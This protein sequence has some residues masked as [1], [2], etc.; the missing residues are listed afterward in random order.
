MIV[1]YSRGVN[2]LASGFISE[3]DVEVVVAVIEE[4]VLPCWE[5]RERNVEVVLE[6]SALVLSSCAT[7]STDLVLTKK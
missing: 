2:S 3:C 7:S 1:E 5:L 4:S 6:D